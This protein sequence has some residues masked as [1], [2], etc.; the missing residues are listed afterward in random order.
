[1]NPSTSHPVAP[2]AVN[3]PTLDPPSTGAMLLHGAAH[4]AVPINDVVTSAAA[5][6]T[7]DETLRIVASEQ[8]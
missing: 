2:S 5:T 3:A 7:T 4:A 6:P 8:N 1:L